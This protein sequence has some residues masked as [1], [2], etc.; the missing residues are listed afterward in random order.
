MFFIVFD[1]M[2]GCASMRS[3]VKIHNIAPSGIRTCDLNVCLYLNLKHGKLATA[4][5]DDTCNSNNFFSILD[6]TTGSFSGTGELSPEEPGSELERSAQGDEEG[7][8]KTTSK[9]S[10]S[11]RK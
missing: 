2:N 9:H 10:D 1:H 11:A 5:S 7:R 8:G 4:G 6:S 3:L